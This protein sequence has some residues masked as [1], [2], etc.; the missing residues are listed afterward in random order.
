M[1]GVLQVPVG[2]LEAAR[3]MGQEVRLRLS[4]DELLH[5]LLLP[6]FH[7]ENGEDPRVSVNY[8]FQGVKRGDGS[9][10]T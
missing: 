1:D 5:A 3:F 2:L 4:V 7:L 10:L 8:A 9:E 6:L